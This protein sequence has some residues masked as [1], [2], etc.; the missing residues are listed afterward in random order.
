MKL[1][2]VLKKFS[3]EIHWI[4]KIGRLLAPLSAN[5]AAIHKKN[6]LAMM[7]PVCLL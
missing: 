4:L 3:S 5:T 7:K 6:Q 1:H 2:P